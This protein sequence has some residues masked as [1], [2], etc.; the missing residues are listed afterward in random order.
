MQLNGEQI[1]SRGLIEHAWPGKFRSAS[2]DASVGRIIRPR[3]SVNDGT[4]YLEPQEMIVVTSAERINLP[5]D[6]AG[7][8]MPKT[9]L[10]IEGVLALSTGI[11][12]PGYSGPISSILI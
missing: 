12:D 11:V 10:C 4:T 5:Q 7:Y 1:E 8:A 2:Y 9:S 3:G 6:I